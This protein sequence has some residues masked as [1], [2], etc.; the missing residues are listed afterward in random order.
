M[1]RCHSKLVSRILKAYFLSPDHPMK[2]RLWSLLRKSL[3]RPRLVIPYMKNGYITVDEQDWLQRQIFA[4]GFY[5]H[6]VWCALSE[7]IDSNEILWDVGAHIGSVS[8]QAVLDPC[9]KEVH[10]FEPEPN[11]ANILEFNI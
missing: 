3:N 6:E 11:R 5:E 7:F 9:V 10:A 4:T 1:V 2:L 8:I